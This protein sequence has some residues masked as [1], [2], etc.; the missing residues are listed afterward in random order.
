MDYL[1]TFDDGSEALAHYGVLGMKWGKWNAETAARY[2]YKA[3][4]H[5][6]KADALR[7]RRDSTDDMREKERLERKASVQ[8]YKSL[9]AAAKTLG[10]SIDEY[11]RESVKKGNAA[12]DKV[13][14]NILAEEAWGENPTEENKAKSDST[15]KDLQTSRRMIAF[16]KQRTASYDVK[17]NTVHAAELDEDVAEGGF[18]KAEARNYAKT[19]TEHGRNLSKRYDMSV[20]ED[21]LKV[22]SI[23][24]ESSDKFVLR[25]GERSSN[26]ARDAI[27]NDWLVAKD[28]AEF[29]KYLD[30]IEDSYRKHG[31]LK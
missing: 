28:K 1:I 22:E 8:D 11:D 27:A 12:V 3:G 23:R 19:V 18:T 15:L 26:L 17:R 21:R 16:D 25:R 14:E 24:A 29:D 4:R 10:V 5:A 7:A 20:K 9:M 2:G 13:L 31:Y 30:S 6:A